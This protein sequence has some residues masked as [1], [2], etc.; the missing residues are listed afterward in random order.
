MYDPTQNEVRY[1]A[2]NMDKFF[3]DFHKAQQMRLQLARGAADERRYGEQQQQQQQQQQHQHQQQ[4][5]YPHNMLSAERLEM[6]HKQ[7]YGCPCL[8]II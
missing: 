5:H 2:E 7:R 8:L 1:L 6:E 4:Q 3:T